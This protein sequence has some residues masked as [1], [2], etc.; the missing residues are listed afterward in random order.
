L[1]PRCQQLIDATQALRKSTALRQLLELA[2]A[3][4]KISRF[5][6]HQHR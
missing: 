3:L 2:L 1:L 5:P 6:A 4:G